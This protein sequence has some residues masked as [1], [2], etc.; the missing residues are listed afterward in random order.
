MPLYIHMC[1]IHVGK[2][3]EGK[4]NEHTYMYVVVCSV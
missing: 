3:S 2:Q 1:S 4:S